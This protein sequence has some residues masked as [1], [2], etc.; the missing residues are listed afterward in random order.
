MNKLSN[1]QYIIQT[2]E[3]LGFTQEMLAIFLGTERSAI[4]QF[5]IQIRTAPSSFIDRLVKLEKQISEVKTTPIVYSED[6]FLKPEKSSIDKYKERQRKILAELKTIN[7]IRTKVQT[8]FQ[9][10]LK[11]EKMLADSIT[12]HEKE[13]IR[14]A[15]LHLQN[16]YKSVN[17]RKRF[18]LYRKYKTLELRIELESDAPTVMYKNWV[19]QSL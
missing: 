9:N 4:S 2:R 15:K 18:D 1:A 5:E 19:N 7:A 10:L 13:A 12:N 17:E 8:Q 14:L 16:R 3:N 6:A 11:L